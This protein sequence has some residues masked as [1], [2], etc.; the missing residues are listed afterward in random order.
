MSLLAENCIVK[1]GCLPRGGRS[2]VGVPKGGVVQCLA[3]SRCPE[4]CVPATEGT[5]RAGSW[6][7]QGWG[8]QPLP[9]GLAGGAPA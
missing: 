4:I 3:Y 6:H 8:L 9:Q 7:R 1:D 5:K 2:L